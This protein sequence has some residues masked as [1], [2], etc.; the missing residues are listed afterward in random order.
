MTAAAAQQAAITQGQGAPPAYGSAP[1][2][3][4][5]YG[6]A[7]STQAMATLYPSLNDYMGLSITPEMLEQATSAV[8][9]HQ[10]GQTVSVKLVSCRGIRR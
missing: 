10:H 4:P 3:A 5:A 8:V 6:A 1:V 7:P 2:A 9:A